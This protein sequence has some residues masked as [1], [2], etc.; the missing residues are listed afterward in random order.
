VIKEINP[1]ALKYF[2]S[3]VITVVFNPSYPCPKAPDIYKLWVSDYRELLTAKG[4]R[5]QDYDGSL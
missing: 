4:F 5:R 2:P 1:K 3:D